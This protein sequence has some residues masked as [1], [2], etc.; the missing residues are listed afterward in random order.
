MLRETKAQEFMN[1]RQ[2]RIKVHEYGLKFNQLSK[3][4]P[5]MFAYCSAL[6]NKF[7]YCV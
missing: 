2:G 5:Y 4:V 3:Y 7:L 1:L 6:M